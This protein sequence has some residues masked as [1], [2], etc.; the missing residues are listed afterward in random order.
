MPNQY[1][2]VRGQEQPGM[3]RKKFGR[4][5]VLSYDEETSKLKRSDH[6]LV[7]CDCGAEKVVGGANMRS[8]NTKS[9][10]CLHREQASKI[11][12]R[13]QTGENGPNYL[14]GFYA[15]HRIFCKIIHERDVVCQI[16][17]MTDEE[18]LIKYGE[19]LTAHHLNGDHYNHDLKN[20]ALLC[21]KDHTIVTKSGNTWRP[22]S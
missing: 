10:G 17:S 19:R 11:E 18:S 14:D 9:C 3:I 13:D 12:K 20:G 6:Y 5:T 15:E 8:G 4:L 22:K 21:K 2:N 1:T 16:C 7:H